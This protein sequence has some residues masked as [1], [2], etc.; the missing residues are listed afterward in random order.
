MKKAEW[1]AIARKA[2]LE[3]I[4]KNW[5]PVPMTHEWQPRNPQCALCDEPRAAARHNTLEGADLTA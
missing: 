4:R 5:R 1:R 3:V 2:E